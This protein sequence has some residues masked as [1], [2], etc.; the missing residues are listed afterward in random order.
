MGLASSPR[1]SFGLVALV[2]LAVVG[3]TTLL[4][5]TIPLQ[6]QLTLRP[7]TRDDIAAYKLPATIQ[8]SGGL[9]T[10]GVGQPAYFEALVNAAVPSSDILG[11]SWTLTRK[12]AN[13]AAILEDSPLGNDVPTFEPSDRLAFQVAGRILLRPDVVGPYAVTAN[14]ATATSGTATVVLGITAGTYTGAKACIVCHSGGLATPKFADWAKTAHASIFRNGMNGVA[15]DHYGSGCLACHTVGYDANPKAVNG[16]FDDVAAQLKWTFP[17]TLKEGTFDALPEELKAVGNIQCENCHGPG[18]QHAASANPIQI[19]VSM[20]SGTCG[21]CHA[22]L[23]HHARNGQWNNSTHAV[24]TRYASGS[25][26]EGCVGCHTGSGFIDRIKGSKTVNT[27]YTS[28]NCQTCHE[29][30]G[31]TEPGTAAH[32]IRQMESV[33]LKDG[34]VVKEGG[35]GMLCMNCHQSR[36]NAAVYAT[37]TVGSARFG[38]HH[39]PQADMLQGVNGFTYGK[40]IPSSAHSFV[41]EDTCVGCH[42]QTV[43]ASNPALT[44]AGGHTFRVKSEGGEKAPKV[45][46]VK[47][48]QGCHGPGITTFDFPL[49]DHNGDGVIEGVQSEVQHLLDDLALLLPPVGQAK[50]ELSIDASWSQPQLEAAYNWL[51][52]RYDGSMGVHNTAYSVGL[53]KASIAN[54]GGAAKK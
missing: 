10:I 11:V 39:S 32:L 25:G 41:V 52:V 1:T 4:S 50:A 7:L 27:A 47:A 45:E 37:T 26:R 19:S 5:Q 44:H 29:P 42:M 36:Q 12:P 15:S 53:L 18:S 31:Q 30:H 33:T 20:S 24:T 6:A 16:G 13:S 43:A 40:Y 9:T 35:A 34:T 22:A 3:P 8:A 21:V 48:C 38:P 23:T 54:L 14:I 2:L 17:T 51:F 28:I 49:L 46:L